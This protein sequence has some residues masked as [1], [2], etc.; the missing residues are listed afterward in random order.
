MY[1]DGSGV[2]FLDQE[3]SL[4]T[5]QIEERLNSPQ[6]KDRINNIN[7]ILNHCNGINM[8]DRSFRFLAMDDKIITTSIIHEAFERKN[9]AIK[10]C[11]QSFSQMQEQLL[12]TNNYKK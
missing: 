2:I 6:V 4:I 9:E 10:N 11:H 12:S 3:E 5:K 7:D 1:A 8:A